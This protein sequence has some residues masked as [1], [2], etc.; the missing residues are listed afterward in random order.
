M[1][2]GQGQPAS[3]SQGPLC[4][5]R[6]HAGRGRGAETARPVHSGAHRL[7]TGPVTTHVPQTHGFC[8]KGSCTGAGASFY[9][10]MTRWEVWG[11][12]PRPQ[13][14]SVPTMAWLGQVTSPTWP[15]SSVEKVTRYLPS[16]YL[17]WGRNEG[18]ERR[19][20]AKTRCS[21]GANYYLATSA[22]TGSDS[23]SPAQPVLSPSS[24][25]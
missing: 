4:R 1:F 16:R 15:P 10:V 23:L 5:L 8:H 3:G 24:V 13:C 25:T 9:G 7:P 11:Q 21:R 14:G 19:T 20:L 6:A 17:P 2:A 18:M 22:K 12:S